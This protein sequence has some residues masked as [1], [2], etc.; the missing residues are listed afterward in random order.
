MQIRITGGRLIDPANGIDARRDLYLARGRVAGIGRAPQGFEAKRV[1]DAAGCIVCPGLVELSA[2]LR[3]PGAEHKATI[4]SESAAAAAGGVTTLCCPPDTTPPID[5][6]AVAELIHLRAAAAA[7]ARVVCQGA[8]TRALGGE[9]LAEMDALRRIGCV[10]V[11]NALEP[12]ASTEVL[13]R[14]L[15]YAATCDLTV[16]LYAEDGWLARNGRM[17]EGVTSTRL[18]IPGIPETAETVAL[19]RDLLLIEQTGARAHFCR[20]SSARGARMIA[21]ARRRGLPVSADVA[22]HHLHLTDADVGHYD[23]MCHVRPPLRTRRDREGL[24][25][26]LAAG[27]LDA[28]CS[29]HQPQD[30]DAKTAPFSATTPGIAGL[31]TLLPL[32][33]ELVRD[34]VMPLPAVLGTLSAAPARILGLECGRLDRDRPADVCIFDPEQVWVATPEALHSAGRN[35]P[36]LGRSLRGRVRCTLLG[37]RVVY[38]AP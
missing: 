28:L 35:S 7:R 16:F 11:S 37:G 26:A 23:P 8:L 12:V 38:Q 3:E 1:I 31:E 15:E 10:G 25:R 13:R 30:H 22:V 6:A 20:I 33:L 17:H 9:L 24:R 34:E 4:A 27:V 2:R 19:A 21:D 18:G 36:F 32:A 29:D 5:T 14:A